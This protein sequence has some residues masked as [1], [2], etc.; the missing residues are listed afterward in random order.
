MY[1]GHWQYVQISG[2]L[3]VGRVGPRIC[4]NPFKIAHTI[5]FNPTSLCVG[6]TIHSP[7]LL[8]SISSSALGTPGGRSRFPDLLLPFTIVIFFWLVAVQPCIQRDLSSFV[9]PI[10]K[11][12][13]NFQLLKYLILARDS[14]IFLESASCLT[15]HTPFCCF[16]NNKHWASPQH[17]HYHTI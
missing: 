9:I 11:H 12:I 10:S 7:A 4:G 8:R 3:V 15:Y 13:T 2:F 17:I 14:G 6:L 5:I 16:S 1:L